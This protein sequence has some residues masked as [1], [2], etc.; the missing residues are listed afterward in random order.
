MVV[1][2]GKCYADDFAPIL[3]ITA[4]EN[5]GDYHLRV[6]FN[7]SEPRVFDGHS[8][9]GEGEVFAPLTDRAVFD[10]YKLDYETLTW[11]NGEVDIAPEYVY[12]NSVIAKE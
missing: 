7:D 10:D 12:E 11:L 6:I 9:I 2:D 3:K 4:V 8:L 5:L 1:R